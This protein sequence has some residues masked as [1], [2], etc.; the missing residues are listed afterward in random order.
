MLLCLFYA[1]TLQLKHSSWGIKWANSLLL[2]TFDVFVGGFIRC[3]QAPFLSS[4][5]T[6]GN[7]PKSQNYLKTAEN[8][9]NKGEHK[10]LHFPKNQLCFFCFLKLLGA[11]ENSFHFSKPNEFEEG[12]ILLKKSLWWVLGTLDIQWH[13]PRG[14]NTDRLDR[15][16]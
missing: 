3:L 11:F 8:L 1:T 15:S 6:C 12:K 4:E 10:Y 7:T 2:G 14:A 16:S 9:F 5:S 13:H